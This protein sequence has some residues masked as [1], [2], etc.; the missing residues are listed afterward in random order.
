M[1]KFAPSS[2]GLVPARAGGVDI[3]VGE[4]LLTLSIVGF[5]RRKSRM[6]ATSPAFKFL[7]GILVFVLEITSSLEQFS[8]VH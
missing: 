8:T 1:S 7:V 5:S 4:I 6:A 3:R 2:R